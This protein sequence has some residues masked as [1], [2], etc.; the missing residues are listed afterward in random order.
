MKYTQFIREVRHNDKPFLTNLYDFSLS[1][2]IYN[3]I[4]KIFSYIYFL[5]IK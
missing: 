5:S 3:G 2:M 4:I 1:M